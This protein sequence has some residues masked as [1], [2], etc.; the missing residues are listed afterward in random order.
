MYIY[1]DNDGGDGDDDSND[2]GVDDGDV[3]V[4][5]MVIM[6]VMV[7]VMVISDGHDDG[8]GNSDIDGDVDKYGDDAIEDDGHQCNDIVNG[9]HSDGDHKIITQFI[10]INTICLVLQLLYKASDWKNL[11][12]MLIALG[13][14]EA[15]IAQSCV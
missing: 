8:N 5:L 13:G 6:M 15:T 14:G 11:P 2:D 12:L 7:M 10:L 9:D 1:Q 3:M 4:I